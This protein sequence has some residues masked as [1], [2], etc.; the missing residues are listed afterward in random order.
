MK[1]HPS[2]LLG[3]VVLLASMTFSAPTA[4][5]YTSV[6]T[7]N[8]PYVHYSS[9]VPGNLNVVPEVRCTQDPPG[10]VYLD[11][12]VQRWDGLARTW[13]QD[14]AFVTTTLTDTATVVRKSLS[15]DCSNASGFSATTSY[16]A[17]ARKYENYT[18]S[19]WAV[20]ASQSLTCGSG[21]GGG[22]GGGWR[23]PS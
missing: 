7:V 13:V 14:T 1:L 16:R 2:L 15:K 21:S 22:G 19:A 8:V 11:A 10:P 18:W 6:C 12:Y 20:G 4:S 5:A 17:V 3:P 9:H 23:L